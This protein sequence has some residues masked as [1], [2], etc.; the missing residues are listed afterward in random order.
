MS[1][2]IRFGLEEKTWDGWTGV[3]LNILTKMKWS[4]T[5]R[6]SESYEIEQKRQELALASPSY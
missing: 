1:F 4:S 2:G 6:S 5:E 3:K